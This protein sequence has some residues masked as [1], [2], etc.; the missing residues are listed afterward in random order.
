MPESVG[1][2]GILDSHGV[3]SVFPETPCQ[4]CPRVEKGLSLPCMAQ[5]TN[6]PRYCELAAMGRAD[7]IRMLCDE[8]PP[9]LPSA[10]TRIANFVGSAV[11]HAAAGFPTLPMEQSEA[12]L[13]V[14][15]GKGAVP[16]C[17]QYLKATGS[18]VKCGC[19]LAVKVTWTDMKC[20]LDKWPAP[21]PVS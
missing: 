20:P 11:H 12:R 7:Y 2:T 17:D 3:T 19:S 10:M 4:I 14:C 6:V 15:R 16:Q 1:R 5:A 13:D 18:C 21:S 8:P 9:Q